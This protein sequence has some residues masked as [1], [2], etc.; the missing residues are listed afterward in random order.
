MFKR[1][2]LSHEGMEEIKIAATD[3][4]PEGMG[5]I[6]EVGGKSLALFNVHGEYYAID[7]TCPHRGGSLGDGFLEGERVTCPIHG[8][9]FDVTSGKG[10]APP[11]AAIKSYKVDVRGEDIF[12]E[13]E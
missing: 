6:V 1:A 8:W 4:V 3:Q 13:M 10:V 9:Q 2:C 7:N 5:I 11:G 12:V